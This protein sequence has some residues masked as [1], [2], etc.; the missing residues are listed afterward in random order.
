MATADSVKGKINNLI[1]KANGTTGRQDTTL[2]SAVD[3]LIAG[4]GNVEIAEG[5]IEAGA[6]SELHYWEKGGAQGGVTETAVSDIT[7]STK[8]SSGSW[9]S[10][11]YSDGVANNGGVLTLVSPKT[12][13]LDA[14]NKD[15]VIGKCV[16]ASGKFYRIPADAKM[17][18]FVS[19]YGSSISA[20]AA[21][22]LDAVSADGVVGVIVSADRS[23]YPDD[24]EQNG[25]HYVYKGTLGVYSGEL[26]T[27]TSPGSAADLASGKQLING[28]GAIVTGSLFEVTSGNTL[29]GNNDP[30][31]SWRDDGKIET[32]GT[33]GVAGSGDGG[34]VRPGAKFAIR[35]PAERYGDATA[36]DVAAGK[37]FTSA[38][39]L[40]VI[41]TG[42]GAGGSG[43]AMK[44]GTTTSNVIDTGL[45]EIH[46]LVLYRSSVSS[47]GLVQ[48][49]YRADTG[50]TNCAYCDSYSNTYIAYS[51]RE[52]SYGTADGGT[53]TWSGSDSLAISG[54][55]Y[56]WI[57]VGTA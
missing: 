55:T 41:G 43:L 29:Y 21:F 57:A 15:T 11:Q 44:T 14:T 1:S 25:Y 4:Y 27:L 46:L 26:P 10:I 33:Y 54:T 56:N 23:A 12:L 31:L 19:S 53:Y 5:T 30:V 28:S 2:T 36:A 3:A 17:T 8:T 40:K 13:T 47:K 39:G 16:R 45:S 9:S 51:V 50:K 20:S 7:V 38:A 52:T 32:V 49:V 34:I 37:T 6:L 24:G 48:G 42:T 35:T 18:L 22:R